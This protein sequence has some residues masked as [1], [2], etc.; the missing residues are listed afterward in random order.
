[1]AHKGIVFFFITQHNILLKFDICFMKQYPFA[2]SVFTDC[3]KLPFSL[4]E[5]LSSLTLNAVSRELE[6]Y[7]EVCEALKAVELVLCF[8]SMTGGSP[9]M[10]LVHYLKDK[11]KMAEQTDPRI[12]KVKM[13]NIFRL[14]LPILG[15]AGQ[16]WAS[17]AL[18]VFL[19][20]AETMHRKKC[21]VKRFF[22][23]V[24]FDAI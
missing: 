8:L 6:L 7:S 4:Q 12:L 11:L 17:T 3:S 22:F 24:Y 19:P 2:I 15:P 10:P 16:T 23:W 21:S 5:H 14:R 1:M 20:C 13:K 9:L 18:F